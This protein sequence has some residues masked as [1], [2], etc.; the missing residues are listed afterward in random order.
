MRVLGLVNLILAGDGPYS[1]VHMMTF[2]SFVEEDGEAAEPDEVM[3]TGESCISSCTDQGFRRGADRDSAPP[4]ISCRSPIVNNTQGCV[5]KGAGG[6]PIFAVAARTWPLRRGG[7]TDEGNAIYVRRGL[8]EIG[9]FDKVTL[10]IKRSRLPNH[11]HQPAF[12]TAFGGSVIGWVRR[13]RA[14]HPEALGG[15]LRRRQHGQKQGI[16]QERER[17]SCPVTWSLV[18]YTK[19]VDVEYSLCCYAGRSVS[20]ETSW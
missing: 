18:R 19:S 15:K 7:G 8:S 12:I 2:A 3:S 6:A 4:L 16:R 5:L 1:V 17:V 9:T 10:P 11:L 13:I 14:H 20:L